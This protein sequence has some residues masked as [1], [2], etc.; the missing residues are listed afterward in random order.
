M[1]SDWGMPITRAS[2]GN[3]HAGARLAPQPLAQPQHAV[4]RT[5]ANLLLCGIAATHVAPGRRHAFHALDVG[6]GDAAVVLAKVAGFLAQG[7]LAAFEIQAVELGLDHA[8]LG[9]RLA[10]KSRHPEGAHDVAVG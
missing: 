10:R 9:Q 3:L 4:V 6:K 7:Y 2:A 5:L 1:I 8:L